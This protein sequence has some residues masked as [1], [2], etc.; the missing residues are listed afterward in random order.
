MH[1][2]SIIA[3]AIKKICILLLL[4]SAFDSF[5]QEL[6][7][8]NAAKQK[9]V[10][11][12]P[13]SILCVSYTG[14]NGITEFAKLTVTDITDSTVV[15]GVNTAKLGFMSKLKDGPHVNNYKVI[16]LEDIKGF[17][18]ITLGRTTLKTLMKI[19]VVVG[20]YFFI[21]ELSQDGGFSAGETFAISAGA[22]IAGTILVN[23]LLPENVKYYM[24]DG[25]EVR[26]LKD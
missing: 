5:A 1:N 17:R 6:L 24:K 15:L 11:V 19:G 21:Y 18:R 4:L 14:Y 3:M 13:G 16:R 26:Y 7:F 23:A 22:G 9:S 10:I 8:F 2:R 20:T 12:R 25:W